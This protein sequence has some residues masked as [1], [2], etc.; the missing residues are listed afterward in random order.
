MGSQAAGVVQPDIPVVSAA[1]AKQVL[2]RELLWHRHEVSLDYVATP[3]EMIQCTGEA[4]RPTGI[5][6]EDLPEAKIRKIPAL[7]K[8]RA[9]L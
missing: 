9:A 3:E 8:L 5:Y 1:H 4:P 7:Q 6:W 2:D